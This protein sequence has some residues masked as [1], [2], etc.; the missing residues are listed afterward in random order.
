MFIGI[1]MA[2]ALYGSINCGPFSTSGAKISSGPVWV[3]SV[4]ITSQSG[5]T[6]LVEFFDSGTTYVGATKRWEMVAGA[7]D[8]QY[9]HTFPIP[10]GFDGGVYVLTT[11]GV[12]TEFTYI[13][14]KQ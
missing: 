9:C 12:T 5:V 2:W 14:G 10:L 8:T 1:P 4:C 11:T 6:G 13:T 7:E 3:S